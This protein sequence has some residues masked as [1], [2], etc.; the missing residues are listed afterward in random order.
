MESL[1]LRIH[2]IKDGLNRLREKKRA[3]LA[4][5]AALEKSQEEVSGQRV[6]GSRCI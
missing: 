4:Y 3:V 1:I 5:K 2:K 6:L